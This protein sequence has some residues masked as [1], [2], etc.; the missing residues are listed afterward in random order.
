M[1]GPVDERPSALP[2][3]LAFLRFSAHYKCLGE[4]S[5]VICYTDHTSTWE[6]RFICPPPDLLC[7]KLLLPI[8]APTHTPSLVNIFEFYEFYSDLAPFLQPPVTIF[9]YLELS[10]RLGLH[11]LR[12]Q[13]IPYSH[14]SMLRNRPPSGWL[15]L[16]SVYP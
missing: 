4:R 5:F 14:S 7:V 6:S 9:P 12:H 10:A 15:C 8:T 1:T 2:T 13:H 3:D 11:N 16:I